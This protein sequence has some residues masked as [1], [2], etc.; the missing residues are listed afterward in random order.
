MGRYLAAGIEHIFLGY[1]HIAFLIAVVT[2]EIPLLPQIGWIAGRTAGARSASVVYAVSGRITVLGCYW[3]L[4][5][6]ILA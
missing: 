2:I 1:D 3:F 6:T 4:G 5:R